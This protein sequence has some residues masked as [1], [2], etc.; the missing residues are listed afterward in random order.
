MNKRTNLKKYFET[1]IDY[2]QYLNNE[3]ALIQSTEEF[4]FRPYHEL[5]ERRM[6]RNNKIAEK[7]IQ[8]SASQKEMLTNKKILIITEGWCGDASQIVPYAVKIGE[9]ADIEVKLVYRDKNTELMNEYL[10]NGGMAIPVVILADEN[11][12]PI[13]YFAPR[14]KEAQELMLKMKA[15]DTPKDEISTEL[16]KWY[17]SDKGAQ[18]I[19]EIM[20]MTE[21]TV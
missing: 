3:E 10:T 19:Q 5:N 11:Y 17:N 15:D 16:Q 7:S 12:E 1:G 21:L 18:T 20:A 6:K 2:N 14:P 4:E 8:I 13:D 9:K